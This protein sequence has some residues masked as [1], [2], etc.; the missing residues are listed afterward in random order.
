MI[1]FEVVQD[2]QKVVEGSNIGSGA[3]WS[4]SYRVWEMSTEFRSSVTGKN[5][6]EKLGRRDQTT[7]ES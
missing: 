5:T 3:E 6:Y 4:S 2:I 1:K 7:W